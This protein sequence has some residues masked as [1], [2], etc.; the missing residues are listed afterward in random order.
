M[1]HLMEM[2]LDYNN[3]AVSLFSG[4]L[5]HYHGSLEGIFHLLSCRNSLSSGCPYNHVI[6]IPLAPFLKCQRHREV[7]RRVRRWPTWLKD[8]TG[9]D[10]HQ[11][12]L[13]L[14]TTRGWL[15][16]NSSH[17]IDNSLTLWQ[18][19]LWNMLLVLCTNI[20]CIVALKEI[21]ILCRYC[22]I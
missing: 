16:E 2:L 11:A 3:A 4:F 22:Y 5:L 18:L 12:A 9:V 20:L 14:M 21:E 13:L 17:I 6:I 1:K 15:Q 8:K 10:L 19:F 7:S